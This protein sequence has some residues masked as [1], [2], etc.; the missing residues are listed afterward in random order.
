MTVNHPSSLRQITTLDRRGRP[1]A[2][3]LRPRDALPRHV[4]QAS[5]EREKI[6]CSY[7]ASGRGMGLTALLDC[8]VSADERNDLQSA[9]GKLCRCGAA[10]SSSVK[11]AIADW[12]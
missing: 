5:I 9:S 10:Q 11:R 8:S 12:H 2:V 1:L 4:H 7:C 6:P 3:T